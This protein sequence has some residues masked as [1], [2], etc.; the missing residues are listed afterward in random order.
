MKYGILSPNDNIEEI[1]E[2]WNSYHYDLLERIDNTLH[3][4]GGD[5]ITDTVAQS[6]P[7]PHA[8]FTPRVHGTSPDSGSLGGV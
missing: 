7:S 6:N 8:D 1:L 2:Q 5:H 4:D 3:D